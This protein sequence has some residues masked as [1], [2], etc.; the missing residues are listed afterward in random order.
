M[1]THFFLIKYPFLE[2]NI[3]FFILDLDKNIPLEE[4]YL[5]IR[6]LR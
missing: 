5:A 2:I 6:Y 3:F 1:C 4:L